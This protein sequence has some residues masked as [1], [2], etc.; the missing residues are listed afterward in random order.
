MSGL[1]SSGR[2]KRESGYPPGEALGVKNAE[3]ALW[4]FPLEF[5]DSFYFST[6]AGKTQLSVIFLT[7]V[8]K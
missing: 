6:A 2:Q 1:L 7:G 8:S 4:R 5:T 3:T